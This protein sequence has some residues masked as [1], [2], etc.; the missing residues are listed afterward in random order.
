MARKRFTPEQVITMLREAEV[1][2]NQSNSVAPAEAAGGRSDAGQADA[3][4][5]LI[6]IVLKPAEERDLVSS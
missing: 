2:L 1:L 5:C 3:P 6:K 4:G